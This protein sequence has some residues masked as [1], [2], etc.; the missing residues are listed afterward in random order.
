MR[1]KLILLFVFCNVGLLAQSNIYLKI[2]KT[3]TLDITYCNLYIDN[4]LVE[5]KDVTISE[6]YVNFDLDVSSLTTGLHTFSAQLALPSGVVTSVYNS[7]FFKSIVEETD[8]TGCLFYIDDMTEKMYDC[9]IVDSIFYT[10]IDVSNLSDGFHKLT[11]CLVGKNGILSSSSP[12][13]FIKQSG[14]RMYEY[15]LNEEYDKRTTEVLS[16]PQTPF[17]I[18]SLLPVEAVPVR[19]K[20]FH[21]EETDGVPTIYAKNIFNILFFYGKQVVSERKS[22][23]DYNVS[24]AIDANSIVDITS[25]TSHTTTTPADNKIKWYKFYSEEGDSIAIHTDK[26]CSLNIFDSEGNQL[27][28]ATGIESTQPNGTYT[29]HN[30]TY[31]IALHDVTQ[32][33]N[34]ITLHYKHLDKYAVVDYNVHCVGNGGVSTI[35]LNGNGYYSLQSVELRKDDTSIHSFDIKYISNAKTEISFDFFECATGMYDMILHFVD[36][37]I[38]ISNAIEVSDAIEIV[39]TSEVEYETTFLQGNTTLY[40]LNI[41]NHG[42]MSAYKVPIFTYINC[43][44]SA[45]VKRI[46]FHGMELPNA[47]SGIERDNFSEY[48]LAELEKLA[49]EIGD[50]LHFLKFKNYDETIG[51][52]IYVMSNYLFID[53]APGETKELGLEVLTTES[54]SVYFTTPEDWNPIVL[55]NEN[56]HNSAKRRMANASFKD[57]YCCVADQLGCV[58]DM[59]GLVLGPLELAYPGLGITSCATSIIGQLNS[60][61]GA[62]FCGDGSNDRT[63]WDNISAISNGISIHEMLRSCILGKFAK[64]GN[65]STALYGLNNTTIQLINSIR[66]CI[67]SFTTPKPGCPPTP[68]KGGESNP[69][70]SYDP[71]DIIGYTAP[72]GSKYIGIDKKKISYTIEFENDSLLATAP[73]RQVVLRDTLDSRIFDLTTITPRN[74]TIG[75]KR[76]ELDGNAPFARTIDMRPEINTVVLLEMSIEAETGATEWVF[77]SLDPMT[78]ELTELIENGFLPINDANGRG[79]GSVTFDITLRDGLSDGT[80]IENLAD[81]VFDNNETIVTPVWRNET[82]YVRPMGWVSNMV[83]VNDSTIDIYIDGVDTRSGLWKHDL[84]VQEGSFA[85]WSLVMSD[86]TEEVYRYSVKNDVEYSF[87]IVSTDMAGNREK[88]DLES[89]YYYH[90]GL[91]YS[92]ITEIKKD[93]VIDGEN[94]YLYDLRGIRVENP[95]PG[96][97]VRRGQKVLI[98]Y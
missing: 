26:A 20:L 96:I 37:D 48:E 54:V 47:I 85:E 2:P 29:L 86:I 38:V 51:D 10:D 30:G 62:V 16:E 41:T 98:R 53:L 1:Y 27:Y 68:P 3:K 11:F 31:Y 7:L 18:I 67:E 78:M 81:I 14:I 89:E 52:S 73:A 40:H 79:Q 80:V 92:D 35:R 59:L 4:N 22:Y 60:L 13:Y 46:K 36:E 94:D 43:G 95:G 97:Y 91:I 87:C 42:N 44:R 19:S 84:Y 34:N 49:D 61:A 90:N 55:L 83:I 50:N 15:W 25:L 65:V 93:D 70:N 56:G 71:N 8:Y 6:D 75:S 88:D 77:S 17:S 12:A 69:V 72:S 45:S 66:S 74:L 21:F 76:I 24:E 28:S 63:T 57:Q 9:H 82:D 23:I 58:L 33:G 5:T 64:I 39:I 32:K